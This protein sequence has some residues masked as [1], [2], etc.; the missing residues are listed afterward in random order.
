MKWFNWCKKRKTEQAAGFIQTNVP[1]VVELNAV[2][3]AVDE[4]AQSCLRKISSR[5][6]NQTRITCF[7]LYE[8]TSFCKGKKPNCEQIPS[9]HET[10]TQVIRAR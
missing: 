1:T 5:N 3:K 4:E 8:C 7:A 6:K 9:R 10:V 2:L